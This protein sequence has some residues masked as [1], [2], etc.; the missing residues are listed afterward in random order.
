MS[1]RLSVPYETA[2]HTRGVDALRRDRVIGERVM[3][4]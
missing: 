4:T 2:V 1:L 3:N